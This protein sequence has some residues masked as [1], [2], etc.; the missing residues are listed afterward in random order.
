MR[1]LDLPVKHLQAHSGSNVNSINDLWVSREWFG[2][3]SELIELRNGA[4]DP[5]V[6]NQYV[7]KKGTP[8][9]APYFSIDTVDPS[10]HPSLKMRGVGGEF[11]R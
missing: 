7:N 8:F 1:V 4:L 2:R 9:G 10:R 5:C 11:L 3:G 6:L